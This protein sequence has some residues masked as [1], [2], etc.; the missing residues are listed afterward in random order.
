MN[1]ISQILTFLLTYLAQGDHMNV[2][3]AFILGG[4]LF[5]VGVVGY[6]YSVNPD[7][8]WKK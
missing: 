5:S 2:L 3:V 8:K 1:W 4:L 6:L 7:L